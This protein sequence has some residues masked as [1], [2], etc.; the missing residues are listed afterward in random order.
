MVLRLSNP[1]SLTH[2]LFRGMSHG[3][4]TPIS[5][6]PAFL[7]KTGVAML[8]SVSNGKRAISRRGL[9]DLSAYTKNGTSPPTWD[10]YKWRF[11]TL[12]E[13]KELVFAPLNQECSTAIHCSRF[14]LN[15]SHESPYPIT[16]GI[17]SWFLPSEGTR[18]G[19]THPGPILNERKCSRDYHICV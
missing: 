6:I 17:S 18:P 14:R 16:I 3:E 8:S 11:S 5:N 13:V 1:L 7:T 9:W 4:P 19:A 15:V 12:V 2:T 10:L